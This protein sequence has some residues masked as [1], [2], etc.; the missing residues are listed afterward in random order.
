MTH[1]DVP[2]ILLDVETGTE[3]E[4][5]SRT[6]AST[7]RIIL[8]VMM[9]VVVIISMMTIMTMTVM[10]IIIIIIM[11]IIAVEDELLSQDYACFIAIRRKRGRER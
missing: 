3:R 1:S 11:I 5:G 4:L 2:I 9:I 10:I 6:P 7:R 8:M